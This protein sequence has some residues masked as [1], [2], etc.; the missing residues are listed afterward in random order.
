MK[1]R[2]YRLK[3]PA[4]LNSERWKCDWLHCAHGMGLAGM[5]RCSHYDSRDRFNFAW[6][7]DP[8]CPGFITMDDFHAHWWWEDKVW[9]MAHLTLSERV[10]NDPL[11]P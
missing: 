11:A 4:P 8:N 6:W 5:G 9:R 7:W 1:Y 2:R 3:Y 10:L